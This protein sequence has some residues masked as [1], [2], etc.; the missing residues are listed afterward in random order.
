MSSD[1]SEKI[2]IRLQP[3]L[4]FIGSKS[5]ILSELI[6]RFPKREIRNYIEPFLG[7]GSVL[8][9]VLEQ[10][11]DGDLKIDKFYASDI[12]PHII[13]LFLA[14]RDS[15]IELME[16]VDTLVR[17]G[18]GEREYYMLREIFRTRHKNAA[19][20][21]YLQKRCF[22][23]LYRENNK[24]VFNASYGES[25][26]AVYNRENILNL[27]VLLKP[28][29][30]EILDYET[31]LKRVTS[32]GDFVYVDPPYVTTFDK[33]IGGGFD[34]IR[35]FKLLLYLKCQ[36]L[37][38]NSI[39]PFKA[40]PSIF[41]NQIQKRRKIGTW[42]DG[43]EVFIS[44][45]PLPKSHGQCFPFISKLLDMIDIGAITWRGNEIVITDKKTME[46]EILPRFFKSKSYD[47]FLRQL[48]TYGFEQRSTNV[49]F[50]P[51]FSPELNNLEK[52]QMK[53]KRKKK[54]ITVLF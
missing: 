36:F 21:L 17:L 7:G 20:F 16:E 45:Y 53:E 50:N 34:H 41:S 52:I 39:N 19:L 32:S 40:N 54:E 48:Y 47:S 8:I 30:F 13:S 31:A 18:D 27:S 10:A 12:N 44:N 43:K 49:F 15:P 4:R 14:I 24:G 11:R 26:N 9:R 22:R 2:K 25:I 3:P 42:V 37:M 28:V 46:V 6:R 23:G 38:T 1:S 51:F 35:L 33:Y 5:D 29:N